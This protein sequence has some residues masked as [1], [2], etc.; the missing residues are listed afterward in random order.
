MIIIATVVK[1][2]YWVL[3]CIDM[4]SLIDYYCFIASGVKYNP[5]AISFIA[6]II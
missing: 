4:V 5:I 1:N 3:C 2:Q 6:T